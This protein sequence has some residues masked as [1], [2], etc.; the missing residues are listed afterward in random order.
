MYAIPDVLADR[1][2]IIARVASNIKSG[3]AAG[4][5]ARCDDGTL[6]PPPRTVA[7]TVFTVPQKR[8]RTPAIQ[9]CPRATP[10]WGS[11]NSVGGMGVASVVRDEDDHR[12]LEASR[13]C[14]PRPSLYPQTHRSGVSH[15]HV[16][17]ARIGGRGEELE[18]ACVEPANSVERETGHGRAVCGHGG[19]PRGGTTD[20]AQCREQP[21]V[22]SVAGIP[23]RG[24]RDESARPDAAESPTTSD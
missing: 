12:N 3:A 10:S 13:P 18:A 1:V 11:C 22:R 16:W 20:R 23:P 19:R 2:L 21:L 15:I 6:P 7:P 14:A 5:G 9:G 4:P 24:A 17:G 8:R